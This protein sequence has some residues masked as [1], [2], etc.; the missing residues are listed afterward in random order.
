MAVNLSR[1]ASA[2]TYDNA[3]SNLS[4]RQTALSNLQ[5]NLTSGK[6]VVRAS[7]DPTGAAQAERALTR[8][9]RI[10]TDQRALEAQRNTIANAES[11]LGDVVDALQQFRE[12]VVSA[13][14]G[15]HTP[16]E[17]TTIANQLQGLREQILGYANRKDTNGQPLFG[18]LA[19]AA[20]PFSGPSATAPDYTYNGLPGQTATSNTSI[21]SALD[22]ESA[23]MHQP[24]RDGVYNVSVGNL[25]TGSI[26]NGRALT[27]GNV[28]VTDASLV[29]RATYK[30]T[31]GPV[32]AGATAG[33]SSTSYTIEEIPATG[34]L[35]T[36]PG[37]PYQVGPFTV[38]DYPS[39]KPV[40]VLIADQAGPPAITGMPG[41][42]LTITGTPAAGDVVTVDPNP[43]IFSV[44]DDAIRDIGGA[45]NANAATQAVGQALHNLDIGMNRVS[46]IRGQ[47]GDLLNR[48][49]R[50]TSNQESKSIQLEADR[51]RAEDLDMIKGVADF[52]NQQTA[53]QAALQ[54]YAQVQKLSLFN[55]IS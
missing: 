46:A 42:S 12:L 47:A 31:F 30:I 2:N 39:S 25:T 27:T 28:S 26:S 21:A 48:A 29:T 44:M 34:D 7:D 35:P 18:A 15:S 55:F 13:G 49:D 20:E 8:L 40:S 3:L 22:G 19:S 38:P 45:A 11:T 1:L 9:S 4:K 37:P 36:F 16:A 51:S 6:R 41:L 52:Q 33:T 14:N 10:A 17:R 53:Y 50:I 23:F 5:E 43:S 32:V 54:S 24:S